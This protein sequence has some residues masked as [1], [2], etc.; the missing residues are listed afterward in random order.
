MS[1]TKNLKIVKTINTKDYHFDYIDIQYD[2]TIISPIVEIYRWEMFNRLKNHIKSVFIKYKLKP[3]KKSL[4][5]HMN[6]ILVRL[7]FE[8][9]AQGK[10]SHLRDGLFN[11][12]K[13]SNSLKNDIKYCFT[14]LP[15]QTDEFRTQIYNEINLE[16]QIDKIINNIQQFSKTIKLDHVQK[17]YK[18]KLQKKKTGK[19]ITSIHL[20]VNNFPIKSYIPTAVYNKLKRRFVEY[21]KSNSK[22]NPDLKKLKCDELITCIMIRYA[23]IQ[24]M[25]NQMGIPIPAK[26]QF[27]KCGINFEGFASSLN[28]YY[29]YYCS[30]FY[31]LEKYF[32]SLG[33]FMN[34]T[35]KRGLY[36]HNPPYEKKLLYNMVKIISESLEESDAQMCFYFGAPIWSHYPEYTLPDIVHNSKFFKKEIFLPDQQFPWY[37]FIK[38]SYATIPKSVRYI[39]ANYYINIKCLKD[40]TEYWGKIR[41]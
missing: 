10:I 41:H 12:M 4:D 34:I 2:N 28:H 40:S 20:I 33:S 19:K 13:S 9:F 16:G 37:D 23:T 14:Y 27:R 36:M 8:G 39:M 11:I 25:G 1:K 24:S 3:S 5:R 22:N 18:Y 35:Y 31:D 17:K 26:Q 6:N 15:N 30:M 32:G 7:V 38:E 29:K 21:F